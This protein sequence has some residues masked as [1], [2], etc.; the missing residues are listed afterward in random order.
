MLLALPLHYHDH[1]H[2]FQPLYC[3]IHDEP[4][5]EHIFTGQSYDTAPF[6]TPCLISPDRDDAGLWLLSTVARKVLVIVSEEPNSGSDE[7]ERE[8]DLQVR[9]E[10]GSTSYLALS[11]CVAGALTAIHAQRP[12]S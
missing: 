1:D 8:K 7:C 3:G 2:Q 11:S 5:N 12:L 4:G 10:L 9:A 6:C